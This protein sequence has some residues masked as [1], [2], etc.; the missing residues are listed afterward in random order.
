MRDQGY[1][2]LN[3]EKYVEPFYCSGFSANQH[4]VT[5]SDVITSFEVFEHLSDPQADLLEILN[6]APRVVIFSTALYSGQGLDWDYLTPINGRHVFFYSATGLH[7]FASK[8]GFVFMPGRHLHMLLQKTRNPFFFRAYAKSLARQV[9]AGGSFWR[10]LTA[11]HF[12]NRQRHAQL[13][14]QAD[15]DAVKAHDLKSW[16]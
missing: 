1:D 10:L 6:L 4:G 5:Q 16:S 12:L 13:Y 11:L 14:H 8:H 7:D 9:L 3:H 2:F 15:H